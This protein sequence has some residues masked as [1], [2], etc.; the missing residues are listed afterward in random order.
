VQDGGC[1]GGAGKAGGWRV[2]MKGGTK[3]SLSRDKEIFVEGQRE[4]KGDSFRS[5]KGPN[6][7]C[8]GSI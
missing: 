1:V 2:R 3:R 5:L 4:G 6:E 8:G 7:L